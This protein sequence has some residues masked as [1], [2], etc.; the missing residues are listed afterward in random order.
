M[1]IFIET[2]IYLNT[3][4]DEPLQCG[5]GTDHDDPRTEAGPHSLEPKILGSAADGRTLSFVH[6]GDNG[7]GRM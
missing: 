3:I 2:D 5:K 6:V 1:A 7:V 4:V